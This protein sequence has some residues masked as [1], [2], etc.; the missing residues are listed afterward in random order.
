MM[1]LQNWTMRTLVA[2]LVSMLA[3]ATA[4]AGPLTQPKAD[5]WIGEQADGYIGL[6]REDAPAEIR[7]LVAEV[8][9][10]RKAGYQAIADKQG[11]PLAEVERVG[12]NTVIEK[13]LKGNYVRDASGV[14][15]KK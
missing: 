6:V 5:G 7:E 4:V 12:G 8:N 15:L 2:L 10:K 3:V 1:K 14:W 9:A 13:T 11:V